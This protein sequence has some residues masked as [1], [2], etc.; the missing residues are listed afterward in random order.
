MSYCFC[1]VTNLQNH[2]F[3]YWSEHVLLHLH[4]LEGYPDLK[5]TEVYHL[6]ITRRGTR[7]HRW[8]LF[9]FST[10]LKTPSRSPPAEL[11]RWQTDRTGWHPGRIWAPRQL[12]APLLWLLV[13]GRQDSPWWCRLFRRLP[14]LVRSSAELASAPA[15]APAPRC[16]SGSTGTLQDRS[17]VPSFN[18]SFHKLPHQQNQQ[19][20]LYFSQVTD[21]SCT[22]VRLKRG[23]EM[24]RRVFVA[25]LLI[26]PVQRRDIYKSRYSRWETRVEHK[27]WARQ[28]H[29]VW[30]NELNSLAIHP[31]E[32]IDGI[33]ESSLWI[34]QCGCTLAAL[35]H[36][37]FANTLLEPLV[38]AETVHPH[39]QRWSKNIDPP[40]AAA[41][42]SKTIFL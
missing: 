25:C 30:L 26:L 29:V 35:T 15:A 17:H 23:W 21:T 16:C 27:L 37:W 11:L 33:N 3:N 9:T 31:L 4:G 19:L 34:K 5:E 36:N 6:L 41:R 18:T 40:E 42:P 32:T 2:G 12:P 7:H 39:M 14:P 8:N 28:H 22:A 1:T 13:S 10:F 24:W 38:A 20:L